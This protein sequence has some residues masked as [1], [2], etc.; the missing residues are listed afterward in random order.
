MKSGEPEHLLTFLVA[1][2]EYA[3]A[4]G[5]V[6]EVVGCGAITRVPA[7]PAFIRGAM[8]LR[9]RAL[10]VIDLAAKLGFPETVV[11]RWTCLLAVRVPIA[12]EPT[13]LGVLVDV[14]N[15]LFEIPSAEIEPPPSFG[16]SVHPEYVRGLLRVEDKLILLLDIE[17]VLSTE[18]LLLASSALPNEGSP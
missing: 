12:G 3:I 1:G 10:P 15:Q 5:C 13:L 7:M 8:N 18:E 11:T 4:L 6:E 14:V 2:E 9:S 16:T 17:R